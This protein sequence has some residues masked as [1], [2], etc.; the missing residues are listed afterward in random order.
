MAQDD[1][2]DLAA[3]TESIEFVDRMRGLQLPEW[4]AT[5]SSNLGASVTAIAR[6][7]IE[8]LHGVLPGCCQ[9]FQACLV[10]FQRHAGS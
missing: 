9:V 2:Q 4:S 6:S 8:S 7:Y 3:C 10:S 1:L 5:E